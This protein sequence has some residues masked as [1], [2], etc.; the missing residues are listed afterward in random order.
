MGDMNFPD[1]PALEE[2]Y[3]DWS[4]DGEKWVH[5]GLTGLQSM[6]A[7]ITTAN[8]R[9]TNPQR[10]DFET[11]E[12][13]NNYF[14]EALE[15][16]GGGDGG[17]VD[18]SDY[19]TKPQ[20][21]EKFQVKGDY[22]VEFTE[23]D[24]TVPSHVKSITT[25]DISRW[26][27]PPT[28]GDGNAD[29]SN[30]YT[31]PQTD[32]KFQVKGNYLTEFTEEDPTVPSHV[33]AITTSDI[34]KW[35]NP[36]T[37][38]G[39]AVDSVNGKTGA[40]NLTYS[41]VGAQVAGSYAASNHNH[42]GVYQPAGSYATSNHNHSGV[43]Q[44]A[45]SYALSNH[46]HN[47]AAIGA[48]YTKSES[49]GKYALKGAGG[50]DP[51]AVKLT[52]D[53]TINGTKTFAGGVTYFKNLFITGV[54]AGGVG[55]SGKARI[56]FSNGAT[57]IYSGANTL[58]TNATGTDISGNLRVTAGTVTSTSFN[59]NALGTQTPSIA[60]FWGRVV[61]SVGTGGVGFYFSNANVITPTGPSDVGVD[62]KVSLGNPEKRWKQVWASGGIAGNTR[63]YQNGDEAVLSV[64]DLV[65]VIKDLRDATQGQSTFESLRESMTGCLDQLVG[66][67]E[68]IQSDAKS[69]LDDLHREVEEDEAR[70]QAYIDSLSSEIE[71]TESK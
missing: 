24:P 32:D 68:G 49:D 55:I 64:N 13:A 37:G 1:S 58:Q 30:Y 35:N 44:P 41:D 11:Q 20:T 71:T 66:K 18:L 63:H 67:L 38:G 33:K 17:N 4:W 28:G 46:T 61:H 5:N 59:T 51:N 25:S 52:G 6:P 31:K 12:D 14:Y 22:L 26:D 39:G 7:N 53:Q 15:N 34:S 56:E 27:N 43:Y 60:R 42:N 3:L 9:L 50:S 29:L 8:V 48:S 23:E 21:D 19:Y 36:P 16:G 62:A 54:A 10:S 2:G 57:T 45:G 70:G 69:H 40:V 65:D 47:Y